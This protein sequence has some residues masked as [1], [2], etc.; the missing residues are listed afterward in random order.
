MRK[1]I[2]PKFRG[3]KRDV[4]VDQNN[5]NFHFLFYQDNA[6]YLFFGEMKE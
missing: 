6:R 4:I 3:F 1:I 5:K 2:K